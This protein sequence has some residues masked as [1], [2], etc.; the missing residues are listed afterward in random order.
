MRPRDAILRIDMTKHPLFLW[1]I[2]RSRSTSRDFRPIFA[3]DMDVGNAGLVR[4]SDRP[5]LIN[6]L[7]ELVAGD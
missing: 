1:A 2:G 7:E 4:N 3:T 6:E 5:T